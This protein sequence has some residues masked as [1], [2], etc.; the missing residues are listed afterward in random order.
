[1]KKI[2]F[3]ITID[4][5]GDNLWAKPNVIETKNVMGLYRFQDLCNRYGFKPV[6]LTNYEM[7][8][9]EKFVEFG[10]HFA[11]KNQCEI[12]MHLHAW[13]SPPDYDLTGNDFLQQPFL[14]EYP[15]EIIESKV[16]FMTDLL[17]SRFSTSI[18]SH[19]AGRWAMNADYYAALG[20]NGYLVD[21]SVTPGVNWSKVK[22]A[23]AGKGG[24]NY[25]S[26]KHN[27]YMV[28]NDS[29]N[30]VLEVPM[31]IYGNPRFSYYPF[32]KKCQYRLP[33]LLHRFLF[34]NIWLRPA[35]GNLDAMKALVNESISRK[36]E[37]L[38]FMIHSSELSSGLNPNFP[39]D[40]DIEQLYFDMDSLFEFVS[41]MAEGMTL[42]DFYKGVQGKI[43]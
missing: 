42:A 35:K 16:S 3:I 40:K 37:Y 10:N 8:M 26:F 19:R 1:M 22:G 23:L 17:R 24:S 13:N 11:R 39:T 12:G 25:Y 5:E 43:K 31:T 29:G 36:C 33:S 34:K 41:S 18:V 27:Y 6:Y 9:D 20:K 4:T 32:L 14:C 28:P 21:C 38:E 2:P 15:R 30:D 7:A